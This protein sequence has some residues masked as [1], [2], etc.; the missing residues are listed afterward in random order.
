MLYHCSNCEANLCLRQR[1]LPKCL[2]KG[3]GTDTRDFGWIWRWAHSPPNT[4]ALTIERYSYCWY[5][6]PM[7]KSMKKNIY[8]SDSL[9]YATI[10]KVHRTSPQKCGLCN[11]LACKTLSTLGCKGT[12][13]LKPLHFLHV[14]K[15]PT[16]FRNKARIAHSTWS[17]SLFN[18]PNLLQPTKNEWTG[19]CS[20]T[21]N[22]LGDVSRT[23]FGCP[24][25]RCRREPNGGM[26]TPW[27]G[28]LGSWWS[29]QTG[30][31]HLAENA[32]LILLWRIWCTPQHS[33]CQNHWFFVAFCGH[34]TAAQLRRFWR[35][36]VHG[37]E[38]NF[39][40][41]VRPFYSWPQGRNAARFQIADR[42]W[43][44]S[45]GFGLRLPKKLTNCVWG[46]FLST[47]LTPVSRWDLEIQPI[48]SVESSTFDTNDLWFCLQIA[49]NLRLVPA[50]TRPF[51][52]CLGGCFASCDDC[53]WVKGPAQ[54]E[55]WF[56]QRVRLGWFLLYIYLPL[57]ILQEASEKEQTGFSNRSFYTLDQLQF[58]Q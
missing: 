47:N 11:L 54:H 52:K 5:Y 37:L 10:S 31:L 21:R 33:G 58:K 48:C 40:P 57:T 24:M 49:G 12:W 39:M 35:W 22:C 46:D 28:W 18:N 43:S 14:I 6:F 36:E 26:D 38:R 41:M 55:P 8:T 19:L 2:C 20:S 17:H 32:G 42:W 51:S 23:G 30:H 34:G 44:Q 53:L 25:P 4:H 27:L 45:R 3:A 9:G 29:T 50:P 1:L 56:H 7:Y 16:W 15:K 13:S